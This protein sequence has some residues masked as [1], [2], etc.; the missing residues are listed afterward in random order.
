MA[1]AEAPGPAPEKSEG[2]QLSKTVAQLRRAALRCSR[3]ADGASLVR[4]IPAADQLTPKDL[5]NTL[6]SIARLRFQDEQLLHEIEGAVSKSLAYFDPKDLAKT[7][8]AMAKL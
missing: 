7:V 5:A 2:R 3:P 8:W 1:V 4:A 6:W